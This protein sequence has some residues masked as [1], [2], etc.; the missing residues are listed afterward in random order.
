M[1]KVVRTPFTSRGEVYRSGDLIK[2]PERIAL[3]TSKVKERKIIEVNEHNIDGF[4]QYL[5][6]RRGVENARALLQSYMDGEQVTEVTEVP[7]ATHVADV[8][9]ATEATPVDPDEA[10]YAD[11]KYIAKVKAAAK[12]AGV[13]FEGRDIKDVVAEIKAKG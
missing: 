4:A 1:P 7:D 3:F 9:D 10:K 12:K 6:L 2:H 11:P 5:E 8:T 13:E